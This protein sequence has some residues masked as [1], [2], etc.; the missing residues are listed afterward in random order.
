[1]SL[2]HGVTVTHYSAA[3]L[4]LAENIVHIE[5][6]MHAMM[7]ESFLQLPKGVIDN[8]VAHVQGDYCYQKKLSLRCM[9][10]L[11][12]NHKRCETYE[13][14]ILQLFVE[15]LMKKCH[16]LVLYISNHIYSHNFAVNC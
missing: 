6:Q 12:S 4:C 5:K 8:I 16:K 3:S 13:L 14:H 15:N 11:N 9:Y 7:H 1:M 10:F 2:C